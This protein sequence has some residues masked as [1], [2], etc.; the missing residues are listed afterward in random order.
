MVSLELLKYASLIKDKQTNEN[1]IIFH[2]SSIEKKE[3][4]KTEPPNMML[5]GSCF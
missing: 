2:Q 5:A 1:Q 4:G 3:S